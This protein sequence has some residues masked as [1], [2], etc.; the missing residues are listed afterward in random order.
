[1]LK[2]HEISPLVGM[3]LFLYACVTPL[4]VRGLGEF[5]YILIIILIQNEF[6]L[7]LFIP[8]NLNLVVR[9]K[10][11]NYWLSHRFSLVHSYPLVSVIV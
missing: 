11:W 2:E 5:L 7:K 1:M 4:P 10:L 9:L 8:N 6:I 3:V